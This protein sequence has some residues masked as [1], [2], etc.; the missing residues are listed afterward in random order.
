MWPHVLASV[1][2]LHPCGFQQ[3]GRSLV[4]ALRASADTGYS[5]RRDM[6]GL[7]A[8]LRA[9]RTLSGLAKSYI[10][11]KLSAFVSSCP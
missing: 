6:A 3:S 9:A 2:H 4:L 10:L 1:N 11:N 5:D 8:R 7:R